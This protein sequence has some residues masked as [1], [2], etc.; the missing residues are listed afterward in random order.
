MAIKPRHLILTVCLLLVLLSLLWLLQTQCNMLRQAGDAVSIPMMA[1]NYKGEDGFFSSKVWGFVP[2]ADSLLKAS[3]LHFTPSFDA[4]VLPIYRMKD[5]SCINT[6]Q[7]NFRRM[8]QV[9]L[10][11]WENRRSQVLMDSLRV[12][13]TSL[14]YEYPPVA[15]VTEQGEAFLIYANRTSN[16]FFKI[17]YAQGLSEMTDAE[18]EVPWLCGTWKDHNRV[19]TL[20]YRDRQTQVKVYEPQSFSLNGKT[21]SV[22]NAA[23]PKT[24][25]E[26]KGKPLTDDICVFRTNGWRLA[27]LPIQS[28]TGVQMAIFDLDSQQ[29][30]DLLPPDKAQGGWIA[31]KAKKNRLYLAATEPNRGYSELYGYDLLSSRLSRLYR[32]KGKILDAAET[33][34]NGLVLLSDRGLAVLDSLFDLRFTTAFKKGERLFGGKLK[35]RQLWMV[36]QPLLQQLR[37]YDASLAYLGRAQID[38]EHKEVFSLAVGSSEGE[39]RPRMQLTLLATS[40]ESEFQKLINNHLEVLPENRLANLLF[41]CREQ[42]SKIGGYV[43]NYLRQHPLEVLGYLVLL[44][45]ALVFSVRFSR[46]LVNNK[47][48]DLGSLLPI[49][50]HDKKYLSLV[51]ELLKKPNLATAAILNIDIVDFSSLVRQYHEEPELLRQILMDFY[52]MFIEEVAKNGGTIG[53]I[54]GDGI[55]AVYGWPDLGKLYVNDARK[56]LEA[57]LNTAQNVLKNPLLARG[58][59][60]EYRQG[61]TLGEVF[62]GYYGNSFRKDYMAMGSPIMLSE[63]I[64]KAA[65]A[66]AICSDAKVAAAIAE[67]DLPFSTEP[68]GEQSYGEETHQSFLLK[69]IN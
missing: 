6:A 32:L 58:K 9:F 39:S 35:N 64:Q 27:T 23:P 66:N 56:N 2:E 31:L 61:I 16:D 40:N 45:L 22:Q 37:I 1:G 59:K 8:N 60:L 19:F 52:D 33:D 42:T 44:F 13:N 5:N 11:L 69:S 67:Y 51:L 28:K 21:H 4:W 57:A 41:R 30:I 43:W 25:L 18:Q 46:Q 62:I 26:V 48:N 20:S 63:L 55:I 17:D 53:K 65:P 50:K 68:Y 54:M 7:I 12:S 36:H 47:I 10:P 15:V 3:Y 49:P 24:L 29:L 14:G 38:I 34:D